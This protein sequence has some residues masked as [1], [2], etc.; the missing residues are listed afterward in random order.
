MTNFEG[1]TM[2]SKQKGDIYICQ[3]GMQFY[4]IK[5]TSSQQMK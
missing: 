4:K 2:V 3:Q 5:Q 1:N